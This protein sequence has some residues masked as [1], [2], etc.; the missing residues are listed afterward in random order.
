M[1]VYNWIAKFLKAKSLK[2]MCFLL[3]KIAAIAFVCF[4]LYEDIRY[5]SCLISSD[6]EIIPF[7]IAKRIIIILICITLYYLIKYFKRKY[8]SSIV[9]ISIIILCVITSWIN[10]SIFGIFYWDGPYWGR[11]LDEETGKPIAGAVVAGKWEYE[12]F[13]W[14]SGG[15]IFADVRETTTGENGLFMLPMARGVQLWPFSRIILDKLYVYKPGY[16]SH[17]PRMQHRWSDDEKTK[18]L[19]KLNRRYPEKRQK[20]S[21]EYHS[22]DAEEY[23]SDPRYASTIYTSIFRVEPKI[24][25]PSI[26]RLN[27]A[28]SIKDQRK[29]W[30]NHLS[31][32][33]CEKYKVKKSISLID[34]EERRLYEKKKF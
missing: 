25:K 12:Q 26:I 10:G 3:L 11:V 33:G 31:D 8:S 23:F 2:G 9:S 7:Y 14:L 16:D 5:F 22:I 32:V 13:Y 20:Y 29:V 21:Q 4:E 34:K 30:S 19:Q 6:R 1:N 28:L 18:W 15:T 24:Y 17:P 27:R